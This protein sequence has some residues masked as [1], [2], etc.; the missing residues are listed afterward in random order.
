MDIL[1][2]I[3]ELSDSGLDSV[4]LLVV[5]PLV[6]RYMIL[7]SRVEMRQEMRDALDDNNKE[8]Y[9]YVDAK[10]EAQD[11]KFEARFDTQDAKLEAHDARFGQIDARLAAHD[12]LFDRNDRKNESRYYDL[13][14]HLMDLRERLAHIEGRLGFY[15]PS[16]GVEPPI[17]EPGAEPESSEPAQS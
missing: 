9:R 4:A 6:M 8:I 3:R 17:P 10:F 13:I 1:A 15:P 11:A 2:L 14:Q 7:Q 16:R 5:L 12:A